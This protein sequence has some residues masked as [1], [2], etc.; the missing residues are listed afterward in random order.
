MFKMMFKSSK[1][2]L[3]IRCATSSWRA[4]GR[5]VT[6]LKRAINKYFA[7]TLFRMTLL[8]C[9]DFVLNEDKDKNARVNKLTGRSYLCLL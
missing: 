2:P 8:S 7:L 4:V 5:T 3:G 6:L 1:W 9:E